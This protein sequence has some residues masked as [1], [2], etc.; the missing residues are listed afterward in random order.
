M[1]CTN[2]KGN[3]VELQ[4]YDTDWISHETYIKQSTHYK[5]GAIISAPPKL[6]KRLVKNIREEI[7]R[8]GGKI[9]FGEM[10]FT[11]LGGLMDYYTDEFQEMCGNLIDINYKG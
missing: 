1:T 5:S 7:I 4:M 11:S 8:L 2:R 3:G 10:T 6:D 9:Y